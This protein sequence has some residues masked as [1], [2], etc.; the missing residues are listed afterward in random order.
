MQVILYATLLC[1]SSA[2][3][4]IVY[5]ALVAKAWEPLFAGSTSFGLEGLGFISIHLLASITEHNRS[6]NA[7]ER[8]YKLPAWRAWLPV[9][10]YG[11]IV[12]ALTVM[13]KIV[14]EWYEYSLIAFPVSGV[15][16]GWVIMENAT[17]R[18]HAASKAQARQDAKKAKQDKKQEKQ[19]APQVVLP[20]P[21]PERKGVDREQLVS[22]LRKDPGA[23]NKALG[24]VFQV[25]AEAI[26]QRRKTITPAELGLTK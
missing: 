9:L 15:L 10:S 11:A 22:L 23:S 16:V 6:L 7:T 26:R 18:N 13:L 19:A 24:A 20:K 12:G 14:P 21:K 2:T 4:Y 17:L 1:L 3:G 8:G 25:S 5:G